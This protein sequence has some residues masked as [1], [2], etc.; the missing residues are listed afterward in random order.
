MPNKNPNP[1]PSIFPIFMFLKYH[2][3]KINDDFCHYYFNIILE[4]EDSIWQK[5]KREGKK[6]RREERER[7]E[8]EKEGGRAGRKE[9]RGREAGRNKGK[10]ERGI[11]K[12][13]VKEGRRKE[14]TNLKGKK[15]FNYHYFEDPLAF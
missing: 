4:E 2:L 6:E 8:G 1:H 10:N 3:T 13:S 7:R 11:N 9:E 5:Q 12:E 15:N 14:K